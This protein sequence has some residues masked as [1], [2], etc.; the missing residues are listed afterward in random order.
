VVENFSSAALEEDPHPHPDGGGNQESVGPDEGN[1][2]LLTLLED[3]LARNGD[4]GPAQEAVRVGTTDHEA[5]L[6]EALLSPLKRDFSS[7]EQTEAS[8]IPRHGCRRRHRPIW[9]PRHCKDT[10]PRGG[11]SKLSATPDAEHIA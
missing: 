5:S 9:K 2:D 8:N 7:I 10:A 4:V 1:A 11:N 3:S 6:P